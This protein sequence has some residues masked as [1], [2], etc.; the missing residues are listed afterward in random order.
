MLAD[1]R[2]LPPGALI[3]A[4]VCIIGS[5]AAGI[6]SALE[7]GRRRHGVILLEA[8]GFRTE[9]NQ[10]G[11]YRGRVG[12]S[13]LFDPELRSVHPPLESVR[14]K[15]FGGT[16]GAWG[17]RCYPLDEI[18]FQVRP[19]VSNSGWP[20]ERTDLTPYYVEANRYA[21]AGAYEY[22]G[23][24]AFPTDPVYLVSDPTSW[25]LD[26][27]RIWRF[28]P[29]TDFGRTYREELRHSRDIRVLLHASALWLDLDPDA[30][31]VN[32]LVAASM[33]GREFRI[34][35]KHY[36]VAA[37][38]LESARLLLLSADRSGSRAGPGHGSIGRYYMTHLDGFV[39]RV[40]FRARAPRNA[41]AY[42]RSHDGVYCRRLIRVDDATQSV[43]ALLNLGTVFYMP[44]P[45]DPSHG[46]SVLSAY[47]LAK[48]AMYRTR[49]GF[50]SRRFGLGREERLRPGSHVRN[51]LHHPVDLARAALRWP[52]ERW[53]GSR[54]VP[55]FLMEPAS[56][57]YRFHF[58]AEQSPSERNSISLDAQRDRFELP[59]AHV[60]WSPSRADHDS[61]VRSLRLIADELERLGIATVEVPGD[62]EEL[63]VSKGG[64][65]LGGTHAM[66]TTRMSASPKTGVVD[67]SCR[68]HGFH[69]LFV[70]SS[71]VFPTSGF[72]PPTLT[73]IALA[74][75]IA[76]TVMTE[77]RTR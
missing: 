40:R 20:I 5:G 65:F 41:Y 46:D 16:T 61:V 37:G 49:A 3:R 38:G 43:E 69:D 24:D 7:L 11:T 10:Q 74:I 8:G 42:E 39:G 70:A 44:D 56:H 66:G 75:R 54:S 53:L 14:Q 17:G 64:G 15:R 12:P 18:D 73:I 68:V 50:R 34:H 60:R 29:P 13:D 21:Q 77:L 36:I 72:G 33:P 26:D 28:S 9:R 25:R 52:G 22:E 45:S 67:A 55:S 59:Q 31:R 71:S 2:Q 23:A 47:A 30:G 76:E 48:E 57:D 62:A 6:T 19:Q 1:G 27:S 35:A 51:V 32:G 4:D 63:T 58:S